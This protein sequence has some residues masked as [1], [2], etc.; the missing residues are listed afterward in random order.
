MTRHLD[1]RRAGKPK[2][3]AAAAA[4]AFDGPTGFLHA[5]LPSFVR[6]AGTLPSSATQP[7][8]ACGSR[9]STE[10][11]MSLLGKAAL[12][13]W[14]DMAPEMHAEFEDWHTHE[15]FA[16][17]L[18]V[19]GFRRATRWLD[20]SGGEG[21]F[22]MYE[23]DDH[24][25]LGSAPYLARLNAPSPWSTKMMPHHR[26]MVR[27]QCRVLESAGGAVARHALTVRLAPAAGA[28]DALRAALKAQIGALPSRPGLVGAHLLRHEAPA[29][30]TTTE[31]QIRGLRDQVAD[32]VL[33]ACGYDFEALRQL[34]REAFG[35]AAL[36]AAGAADVAFS[37][38]Y[39]L[40]HSATPPDIA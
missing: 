7:N 33:V 19:P 38:L 18:G 32:W 16:E 1:Q 22:V 37:A 26:H 13:M 36:R 5:H 10:V 11:S 9:H 8:P 21:V 39:A 15:H 35:D 30:A 31:Q 23:L 17:R 12:A 24:D 29:I 27:S 3:D 34:G 20:A 25:V 4:A 40:S 28:D 14:W 6:L 2:A